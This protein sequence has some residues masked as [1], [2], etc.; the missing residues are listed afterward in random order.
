MLDDFSVDPDGYIRVAA[1]YRSLGETRAQN[2]LLALPA[3][4][5]FGL[6]NGYSFDVRHAGEAGWQTIVA[7][8]PEDV[9]GSLQ[10]GDV[11]LGETQT[12]AAINEP[13]SLDG[14]LAQL[15]SENQPEARLNILRNGAE[16]T[17]VMQL[18]QE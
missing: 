9:A 8:V 14:I 6:L 16:S 12:G 10:Q 7:S 3:L 4:R 18:T 5:S 2:G 11:L 15:V 17:A 13:E 1:R